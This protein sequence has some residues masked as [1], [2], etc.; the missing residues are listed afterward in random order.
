M[1]VTAGALAAAQPAIAP[2]RSFL[3]A[4]QL[5]RGG[6]TVTAAIGG[7]GAAAGAASKAVAELSVAGALGFGAV[8]SG[9]L[10]GEAI[11]GLARCVFKMFLPAF[12]FVSICETAKAYGVSASKAIIP[13]FGAIQV[14]I[15]ILT[16]RKAVLPALGISPDS[17]DGRQL[18][19]CCSFGNSGVLPLLLS[20]ALFR[21]PYDP[22]V[23]PRATAYVS[24][25]LVGW[26][27]LFWSL[28]RTLLTGAPG[29]ESSGGG[30]GVV[31]VIKKSLSPPILG[32]FAALTISSVKPLQ[33]LLMGDQAPL[34]LLF[35]SVAN[36]AK[37]C[38]PAALLVLAG[39]LAAGLKQPAAAPP[40][41]DSAPAAG[42]AP[43][44]SQR[45]KL[46]T[47]ALARFL[48]SPLLCT[49]L[50][51][52]GLKVGILP[53]VASDPILFFSL[54][55]QASMPPAQNSVIMLQVVGK[56][57]AAGRLARLLFMAY[58]LGIVPI[59]L[60]ISVYLQRLGL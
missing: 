30:G 40:A 49:A 15:G 29:G 52:A 35:N 8:R 53:P 42:G 23:L 5:I 24:L 16:M 45:K 3:S 21:A 14:G 11:S 36:F 4:R 51:L 20:E 12:L 38:T 6:S 7:A 13:L 31:G 32:A 10:D 41:Q 9:I 48:V 33:D 25:Y 58:A 1:V 18:Q 39:S 43:P 44:V 50:L 59:G 2:L 60:L 56:Q 37:A 17:E 54:L 19:V 34:G 46:I 22:A 57:E 47:I 55:V 27:P 28:G 26:S